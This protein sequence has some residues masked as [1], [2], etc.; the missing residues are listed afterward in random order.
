MA[1]SLGF[2]KQI[3]VAFLT[4]PTGG[5]SEAMSISSISLETEEG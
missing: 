3:L 2:S 5:N 1:C 4:H